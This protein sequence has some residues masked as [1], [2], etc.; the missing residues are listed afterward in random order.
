MNDIPSQFNNNMDEYDNTLVQ[1]NDNDPN[2]PVPDDEPNDNPVEPD[3][4]DDIPQ[5]E[6]EIESHN[7]DTKKDRV[8]SIADRLGVSKSDKSALNDFTN[9]DGSEDPGSELDTEF[10]NNTDKNNKTT[11]N[12]SMNNITENKIDKPTTPPQASGNPP[13]GEE[14]DAFTNNASKKKELE[15]QHPKPQADEV[16]NPGLTSENDI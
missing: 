14:L 8:K 11:L 10:L 9:N 6:N 12:E 4:G 13:K 1:K 2:R 16:L 5:T 15:Q 7:D 3:K